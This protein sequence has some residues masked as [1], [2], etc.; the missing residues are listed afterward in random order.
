VSKPIRHDEALEAKLILEKAVDKIW[1]LAGCATVDLERVRTSL[2]NEF[3]W[4]YS[5]I[6]GHDR[7]D[8]SVHTLGKRPKVDLV[9]CAIIFEYISIML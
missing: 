3:Q 1:V 4:T 9:H 8:T 7:S 2:H 5:I 6:S